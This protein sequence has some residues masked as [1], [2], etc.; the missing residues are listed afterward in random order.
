M[1]LMGHFSGSMLGWGSVWFVGLSIETCCS[2]GQGSSTTAQ[3]LRRAKEAD[4]NKKVLVTQLHAGVTKLL[5]TDADSWFQ[6]VRVQCLGIELLVR[7]SRIMG[8]SCEDICRP[9]KPTWEF[10]EIGVP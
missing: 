4:V 10:P 3:Q 1:S 5:L 6:V 8:I 7:R 2:Q 9:E